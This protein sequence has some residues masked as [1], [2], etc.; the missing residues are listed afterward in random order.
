MKEFLSK[1]DN[2]GKINKIIK[3]LVEYSDLNNIFGEHT[4]HC[5]N[6]EDEL[7]RLWIARC[8]INNEFIDFIARL[9]EKGYTFKFS[10]KIDKQ[11]ELVKIENKDLK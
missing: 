5:N 9:Q 4:K 2:K 1:P 7:N 8:K 10:D 3:E 11:L 6:L